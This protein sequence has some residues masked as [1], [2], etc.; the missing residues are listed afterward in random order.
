MQEETKINGCNIGAYSKMAK[1][2]RE[3]MNK[4]YCSSKRIE[5]EAY[6][7]PSEPYLA[8]MQEDTLEA[9][10]E[11]L[12]KAVGEFGISIEEAI[13]ADIGK[14]CRAFGKG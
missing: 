14:I 10:V 7:I 2:C 5:A 4:D 3:C 1:K 8:T 13:Q 9:A 11:R 12:N 6:I